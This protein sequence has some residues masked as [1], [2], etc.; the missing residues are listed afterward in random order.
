MLHIYVAQ[1]I[2]EAKNVFDEIERPLIWKIRVLF[3]AESGVT[4][5]ESMEDI[6]MRPSSSY[7]MSDLHNFQSTLIIHDRAMLKLKLKD[8]LESR[9]RQDPQAHFFGKAGARLAETAGTDD[10]HIRRLGNCNKQSMGNVYMTKLSR[11]V[12][13]FVVNRYPRSLLGL[14]IYP[15]RLGSS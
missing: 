8:I 15:H 6:V 11:E 12:I 9:S 7:T 5:N 2:D 1:D 10:N 13:E 4:L 14:N 3:N